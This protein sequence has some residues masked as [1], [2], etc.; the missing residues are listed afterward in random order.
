LP[1]Y[2][3]GT[4]T[5]KIVAVILPVSAFIAAGFEHCVA[6]MYFLP[7]AWL[8]IQTD[9]VPAHFDASPIT[10]SGIIHN[11]VPVTLGNVGGAGFVGAVYWQ[12]I[13][14]PSARRIRTRS[15]QVQYP[16]TP[17]RMIAAAD[18]Q[19]GAQQ[20]NAC[21]QRGHGSVVLCNLGKDRF[22]IN[23]APWGEG[24]LKV[25]GQEVARTAE[26]KDRRQAFT[27]LRQAQAGS[28]RKFSGAQQSGSCQRQHSSV[29]PLAFLLLVLLGD[30]F[31]R[32]RL[33]LI[34]L[35]AFT[36]SLAAVALAL[37]AWSLV[38]AS[39]LIGVTSRVAQQI[40]PFAAELAES[41]RG[42]ATIGAAMSG[43]LCG[44][45]FGR[46]LAGAVGDHHGWRRSADRTRLRVNSL[47]T[48]NFT[49]NFAL[50]RLPGPISLARNCG[51]QPLLE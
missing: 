44:I 41:S 2:A 10:I 25:N 15:K 17:H 36:L 45:L 37:D 5:D 16:T 33:I 20:G 6:N 4:V 11:L 32:R 34:Q 29:S 38:V 51:P 40:V 31:E 50:L 42:G 47:P 46:A 23:I 14:Q 8:L 43:L 9:H 3:G 18:C 48:G 27:T 26:A 22:E 13:G 28:F 24:Q 21:G 35:A 1:I 30:R 49:G 7:L 39:A 19:L 12:S